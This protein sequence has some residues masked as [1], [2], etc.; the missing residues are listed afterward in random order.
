VPA[1]RFMLGL[2]FQPAPGAPLPKWLLKR[3]FSHAALRKP[4]ARLACAYYPFVGRREAPARPHTWPGVVSS[5][6]LRCTIG[7]V[8]NT[9]GARDLTGFRRSVLLWRRRS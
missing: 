7:N 8:D 5:V 4:S 3:L 1:R 9:I 6:A 2:V